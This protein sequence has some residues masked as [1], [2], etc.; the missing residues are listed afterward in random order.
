MGK[1]FI[2][3]GKQKE[4]AAVLPE[5][6]NTE[7]AAIYEVDLESEEVKQVF[8]YTGDVQYKAD[9]S[10]AVTFKSGYF[11]KEKSLIY[12]CTLTEVLVVSTI[13]FKIVNHIS[14][15]SFNDVH[16]VRPYKD[17]SLLVVSTGLDL[18]QQIDMNGKVL[19]EWDALRELPTWERFDKNTDYRK[20]STT[21]PH[22]SHPNFVSVVNDKLW[23][24]RFEQKDAICLDDLKRIAIDIERPHD[25]YLYNSLLYYTTVNGYVV[26]ADPNTA[27]IIDTIDLN[28]IN[29]TY[30]L[31]LG[32][33]RGIT[34]LSEDIAV[35][36]FTIIRKTKFKD[37][38]N[39]LKVAKKNLQR[40]TKKKTRIGVYDLKKKTLIKEINLE[41]HGLNVLFSV[42]S[43]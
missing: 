15:P 28:G 2:I 4:D 32:W 1:L 31:S 22:K 26:I 34:M 11:D 40:L 8:A 9:E 33:C 19:N 38:I 12:A 17:N 5:W 18:L 39:W 35:V 21:K 10:S 27:E 14:L 20:V 43:I 3:G 41:N 30:N 29:N 37:N 6:Y 7:E 16:Y 23:L 24:T 25:G 13:D 42:L 36:G